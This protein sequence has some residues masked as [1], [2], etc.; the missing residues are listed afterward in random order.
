MVL[1][2]VVFFFACWMTVRNNYCFKE[3]SLITRHLAASARASAFKKMLNVSLKSKLTTK[4]RKM[5]TAKHQ[6]MSIKQFNYWSRITWSFSFS[7]WRPSIYLQSIFF[8]LH[9][10]VPENE[11]KFIFH[12]IRKVFNLTN[13]SLHLVLCYTPALGDHEK[14]MNS[15]KTLASVRRF[16]SLVA[17][18]VIE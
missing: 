16:T 14:L 11:R 10:F 2:S 13:I 3:S 9:L 18:L 7:P 17:R 4:Q 1:L 6:K 8:Q 12:F 15:C 5:W